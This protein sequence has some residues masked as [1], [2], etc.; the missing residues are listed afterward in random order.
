VPRRVDGVAVRIVRSVLVCLAVGALAA[1]RGTQPPATTEADELRRMYEQPAAQWPKA[2]LDPGVVAQELAPLPAMSYPKSNPDSLSKQVLGR[3]LFFDPRMSGSGQIACA[4]CHDP[5]LGWADGRRLSIGFARSEGAMNAPSIA[6]SGFE[7]ALFWDGRV[8][9]IEAQVPASLRNPVEMN[10]RIGHATAAIAAIPAYRPYVTAAFGDSRINWARLCDAI[11]TYV[12]SIQLRDTAYDR[13]LQGDS[14][15][16]S[17]SAVRGLHLFRTRARCMNCHSGALL[18][19]GQY[20]HL[21]TSFYGVGNFQG[22]YAVTHEPTDMGRFRT[23]GL[24]GVAHTGPWMHNGLIN[25]LDGVLA[26]YNRGWWQNAKPDENI[27]DATFP[28][29][30]GRIRPLNLSQRDLADLKSFL[31]SLSPPPQYQ[32]QPDLPGFHT[33]SPQSHR[34]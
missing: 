17:D 33:Q 13:F 25:D 3:L 27:A 10:T 6:N 29:L 8:A 18:S 20:H 1:C 31:E 19:D 32:A 34:N 11:A 2:W 26:L 16:L 7:S 5:Q 23:P 14:T 30:D 21:G 15:A 24:R 4:S 9:S 28:R 22:R 12:R